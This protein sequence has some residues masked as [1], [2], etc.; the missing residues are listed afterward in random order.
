MKGGSEQNH[1][2]FLHIF[3]FTSQ[4]FDL[5][6]K[7]DVGG[8]QGDFL[9]KIPSKTLTSLTLSCKVMGNN[10]REVIKKGG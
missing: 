4:M 6:K 5:R 3:L 2:S 9:E 10:I 7:K 8:Q 1:N